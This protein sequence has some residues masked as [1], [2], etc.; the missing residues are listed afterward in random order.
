MLRAAHRKREN[1]VSFLASFFNSLAKE[2]CHIIAHRAARLSAVLICALLRHTNQDAED[3][4]DE[5]VCAVDGSVF[6]KFPRFPE[7]MKHAVVEILDRDAVKF[8]LA[9]E[10]SG[11]GAALATL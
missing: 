1:L 8:V 3:N 4:S 6:E 2:V 9:K 7:M 5:L 10:G 11:Y